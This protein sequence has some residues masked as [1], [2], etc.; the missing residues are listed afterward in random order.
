M[1]ISSLDLK[2]H[3]VTLEV[4]VCLPTRSRNVAS[5]TERWVLIRIVRQSI[6]DSTW[7]NRADVDSGTNHLGCLHDDTSLVE[8]V[9]R[10]DAIRNTK[11]A[12]IAAAF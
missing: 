6:D 10:L 5:A 9:V 8:I 11:V 12:E 2:N 7:T 3:S 1:K 4:I